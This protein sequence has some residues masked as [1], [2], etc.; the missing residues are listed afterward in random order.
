MTLKEETQEAADKYAIEN[1]TDTQNSSEQLKEA[2]LKFSF[3]G[4]PLLRAIE[5]LKM[6]QKEDH[7]E[8]QT[9]GY[10]DRAL[11]EIE[12]AKGREG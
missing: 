1:G 7:A 11:A 2:A 3:S 10:A 8:G 12:A 4:P 6:Y 5:A 9:D